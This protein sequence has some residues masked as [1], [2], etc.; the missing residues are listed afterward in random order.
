MFHLH[1]VADEARAA[2][3]FEH[4]VEVQC[5]ALVDEVQGAVSLEHVAAVAHRGQVGGGV[6][7]AA[8]GLLHDHR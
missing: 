4:L 5:L 3:D 1:R 6:Q 7:V 2:R 8:V